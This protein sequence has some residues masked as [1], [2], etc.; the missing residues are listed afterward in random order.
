[1]TVSDKKKKTIFVPVP[2]SPVETMWAEAAGQRHVKINHFIR[3][4]DYIS[5]EADLTPDI[6]HPR[7]LA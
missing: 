5:A 1:M 2:N 7:S 4:G 6:R 3:L